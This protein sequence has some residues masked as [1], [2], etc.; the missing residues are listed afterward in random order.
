M[1]LFHVTELNYIE[2]ILEENQL[3]S[4]NLTGNINQGENIYN[5]NKYIFLGT[6]KNLFDNNILGDVVIY[7]K[8]KLLYNRTYY[9]DDKHASSVIHGKKINRYN[10]NYN[11][12][13]EK[14]Y[15]KSMKVNNGIAFQ[16][17]QQIALLNKIEIKNN[18]IAIELKKNNEKLKKILKE[19]LP[20]III[21]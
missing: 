1:Y 16:V 8:S 15:D 14:L 4:N 10:K 7:L 19:K 13:L 6:T 17:F 5:T 20:N 21:K 12:I 9:I 2:K 18:L 3:K 11:N